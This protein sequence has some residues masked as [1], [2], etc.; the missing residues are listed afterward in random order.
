LVSLKSLKS[1]YF[2]PQKYAGYDCGLNLLGC[3][4]RMARSTRR[5]ILL[6]VGAYMTTAP[7]GNGDDQSHSKKSPL[8][9]ATASLLLPPLRILVVDDL[10]DAAESLAI[11][12]RMLG[13]HVRTAH[14]GFTALSTADEFLPQAILLD[15]AMPKL[16]GFGV[17]QKLRERGDTQLACLIAVSGYG[18]AADIESARA[19]GFDHH[20]LKPVS[21]G[22]LQ[23]ILQTI[24]CADR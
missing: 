18:Q 15:L 3:L 9:P 12:L 19:A 2:T 4:A 13:Y 17:A 6:V 22:A 1:E 14:D 11:L 5:Y 7:P 24:P 8:H 16:N 10:V 23:A 20:L 21:V